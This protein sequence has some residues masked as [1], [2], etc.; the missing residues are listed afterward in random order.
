[1]VKY[2][3][4]N[5]KINNNNDNN[6]NKMSKAND[7]NSNN[8]NNYSTYL[9]E[10]G[11]SIFKECLSVDEQHY[12]RNELTM[13]PHIPKSP[14]QPTPFPIYLESPLKL[15]IPR[16]FGIE[17]YGPPDR[18]LIKPGDKIDV[19]FAGDLRPYQNAIVD[20]YIKHVGACGGGLLDVDPGKGKTVMALNIISKLQKST[21]VIVHKSFLLNQWIE[22]IQQF[23]PG[24]RVG[25]IQGQ[26]IDTENKDIV[27]GMLQSLSMKEYP[28]DTFQQFGLAIYD[29]C[30]PYDTLV[31][32]SRGPMMIGKLYEKWAQ[33]NTQGYSCIDADAIECG[34]KV[35]NE[36]PKILSYNIST[37][38]FEYSTMTHA[39][40]RQREELLRVY[41]L[42]GSFVCTPDHKILTQGGGYKCANQLTMGDKIECLYTPKPDDIDASAI[43]GYESRG[44]YKIPPL[45]P[46]TSSPNAFLYYEKVSVEEYN[47]LTRPNVNVKTSPPPRR[48]IDVYDIEVADN[49]NFVLRLK[50]GRFYNPI[51][52]NC[53]HMGAE[54]F[55]RCMMKV[56]TTYTLGLSGTMSRK[57]GLTKVFEMFIGPVVHKEKAESEHK[58]L[59]K[60]IVYSVDDEVFNETQYDYMGNPK[61]STM[62]SKLCNY[63]RRSEFILRVITAELDLNPG[64]QIMILAHNKTLLTYLH[65]AISSRKIGEKAVLDAGTQAQGITGLVGYYV[66]GMKE[67]AL[68]ES[69]KKKII[70][71]TYAMASEG[72]DIK[73][74][75]TLILASPKTDVCQSVGRIL[76][77]KHSSPLVIDIIDGHDIFMSQWYKRRKYYKSQDYKILVCDNTEYDTQDFKNDLAKWKVSWAPKGEGAGVSKKTHTQATKAK[78]AVATKTATK[79]KSIAEKLNIKINVKGGMAK[80]GKNSDDEDDDNY[81]CISDSDNDNDNEE[82]DERTYSDS[83]DDDDDEK[84]SSMHEKKQKTTRGKS[85]LA[86]KGCLID[87]TKL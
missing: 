80:K 42:G 60:G 56:N 16:Y 69:E 71:A 81:E 23:L 72:L 61:F 75:T 44:K 74:L 46:T 32:T 76:R 73:T 63:N 27:I 4:H 33:Y 87:I 25:R 19:E 2:T 12:I 85:G 36:L 18:I 20:K 57:D 5:N 1:M 35:S 47:A 8:S 48:D 64:Q 62:I 53:H 13:K 86:G 39:W 6:D 65:D 54:V 84:E 79:G 40:R 66:G 78:V 24:A 58:V 38:R 55:S 83:N 22:R 30:F 11:Y 59:V 41:L 17:T 82:V 9:G 31:H 34:K 51:V 14:I 15:Y 7:N 43:P 28:K 52:S 50:D 67:A 49:H 3:N 29:E 45:G 10:K 21:L 77:Q 37:S 26:I 68:K 70:I